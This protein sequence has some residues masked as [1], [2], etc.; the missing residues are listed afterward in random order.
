VWGCQSWPDCSQ[1]EQSIKP[2]CKLSMNSCLHVVTVCSL[3]PQI[4][5]KLPRRD[6]PPRPEQQ[7]H[8]IQ[9]SQV[10]RLRRHN[11]RR[12]RVAALPLQQVPRG[13]A[14]QQRVARQSP[15]PVLEAA[16][17]R[18][19]VEVP[20]PGLDPVPLMPIAEEAPQHLL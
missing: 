5:T 4:A 17:H 13:A 8:H 18:V 15:G 2:L 19:A 16:A 12:L 10:V 14:V 11:D 20:E 7:A 9:L 6:M 1:S 3:W